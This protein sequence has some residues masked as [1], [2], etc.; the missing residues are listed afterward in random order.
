MS[1]I[2]LE[3]KVGEIAETILLPGDPLRAKHVA[4]TFLDDA[5]CYNNV[6]GMLGFTGYYKGNRVS[7]QGTGMGMG[8]HAIYVHEL[9][10]TYNVKNLIRVGTCGTIQENTNLGQVLLAMSASGDC[11]A[12]SQYFEGL[13]YAATADFDLLHKAYQVAQKLNIKTYQGSVFSTDTF[14]DTKPDRWEKWQ[15]HGI[16][17]VEMETQILFTLAKRFSVNALS[18]LTVSDNIITGEATTAM[19]RQ[20]SFNDMMRIALELA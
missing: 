4:E 3:A 5:V 7:V 8:S 15:K 16:M 9:I 19:E 14:Y 20:E 18:I 11:S 2:H 6:R 17:G 1:S 13:Q 12:N 10:N